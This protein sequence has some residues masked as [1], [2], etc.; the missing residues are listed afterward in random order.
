LNTQQKLA[1]AHSFDVCDKLLTEA[2]M[3]DDLTKKLQTVLDE[4]KSVM[5]A[6]KDRIEDLRAEIE[7]I[8]ADNASLEKQIEEMLNS[9]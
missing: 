8:E 4:L 5:K 9:F 1:L 3:A 7:T 2:N 6:R